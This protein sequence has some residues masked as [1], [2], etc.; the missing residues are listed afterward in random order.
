MGEK[1]YFCMAPIDS[2][3]PIP[4]TNDELVNKS[5]IIYLKLFVLNY[6][7]ITIIRH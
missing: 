2:W 7:V 6:I 1:T 5:F 3:P 4:K